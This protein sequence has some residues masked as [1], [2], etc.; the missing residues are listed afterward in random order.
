LALAFALVLVETV[1]SFLRWMILV[2][3]LGI[4]LSYAES[5]RL[6]FL[7]YLFNL[8][9]AGSVGGDLFKAL[10]VSRNRESKRPELLA[11]VLMDRVVGLVGLIIVACISLEFFAPESLPTTLQY[12]RRGALLAAAV[13]LSGLI[14]I[15]IFG[16]HL[17][18]RWLKKIPWVG[19]SLR[20]M[21][22]AGLIFDGRP[23][24][25]FSVLAI[26]VVVHFGLTGSMCMISS[27]LYS[28]PP[29]VAQHFVVIPPAVVAGALPL[30]PGG[31]GLQEGAIDQLFRDI[32][33]VDK[34]FSGLVVAAMYRLMTFCVAGIGAVY[35][36]SGFGQPDPKRK[37][38]IIVPAQA[39]D[40]K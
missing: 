2:R 6:G 11:S 12:I 25:L 1:V 19:N 23:G 39:S 28:N 34:Q 40:T 31:L 8:V 21:A 4:P 10:A 18:L 30:T 17:P 5:I 9:S 35:Y 27:A 13:S 22:T 38:D 26:S 37:D 29:T 7:G 36:F 33:G 3:A 15:V 14:A 16:R 24:L 32:P 20:R